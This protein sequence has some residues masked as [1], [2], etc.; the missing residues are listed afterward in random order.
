M[1]NNLVFR[2]VKEKVTDFDI[3]AVDKIPMTLHLD[4]GR[5]CV[6]LESLEKKKNMTI[7]NQGEKHRQ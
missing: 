3:E 7:G 2:G 5:R 4:P 1:K 6:E